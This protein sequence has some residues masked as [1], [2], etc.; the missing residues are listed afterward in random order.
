[1]PAQALIQASCPRVAR[2][3]CKVGVSNLCPESKMSVQVGKLSR[4]KVTGRLAWEF[5]LESEF[6]EQK[7][8][9]QG[10]VRTFGG[11]TP[12]IK[13]CLNFLPLRTQDGPARTRASTKTRSQKF[14]AQ[15]HLYNQF[16]NLPLQC[17]VSRKP[18][19]PRSTT[20]PGTGQNQPGPNL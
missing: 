5:K 19:T 4:A 11:D 13:S 15:A 7:P 18:L 12:R 16:C 10:S 17:G 14:S 6:P 20:K 8:T 3:I 2:S 9:K 1:V